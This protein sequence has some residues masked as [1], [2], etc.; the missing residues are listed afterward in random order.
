MSDDSQLKIVIDSEFN[1]RGA[2]AAEASLEKLEKNSKKS[3]E[4]V[5]EGGKALDNLVNSTR[6]LESTAKAIALAS[7]A[8]GGPLVLAAKSY[9]SS[10]GMAESTS[11]TWLGTMYSLEQQYLRVGRVAAKVA[12]P[13]VQKAADFA[14]RGAEYAEQHPGVVSTGIEI[15]GIG[16]A[17]AAIAKLAPVVL[18]AVN[19]LGPFG[20]ALITATGILVALANSKFGQSGIT[21]GAQT[22]TMAAGGWGG[23]LGALGGGLQGFAQG[24]VTGLLSEGG[25]S[26]IVNEA[27]TQARS[28][29]AQGYRT[30]RNE[31]TNTTGTALGV[32]NPQG[33]PTSPF[34]QQPTQSQTP[35]NQGGS[36]ITTEL[37]QQ[38]RQ[39]QI[40][41]RYAQEDYNRSI[42]VA[43]RDFYRQR[44]Y[45]EADYLRSR[46][47]QAR[48]FQI[49]MAYSEQMFYRD[50]AIAARDFQISQSRNEYDYQLSRKRAQEDH[51]FS[52]KQIMLSGDALQYYYSQRQFKIDQQRAE[53]DYQLQKQRNQEDFNRQ[54][55]DSEQQFQL[56]R[57][58]TIKE[59]EIRRADQE[60]D[61]QLQRER[62]LY[63]FEITLS[64]MAYN[65]QRERQRR[66]EGFKETILPEIMLE[67]NYR[68]LMQR[69]LTVQMI[70][71][72]NALMAIFNGQWNVILGQ[73]IGGGGS[74]LPGGRG[75]ANGGYTTPGPAV[76][77]EGEFVMTRGTTQAA[78]RAAK[79]TLTQ[80]KLV[81]MLTQ[82]NGFTYNDQREF[83]RG[84]S[85]D[86]KVQMRQE[87]QQMVKDAFRGRLSQ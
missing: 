20:V 9:V 14:E 64:D 43:N 80:E 39:F 1:D 4:E 82:G 17:A 67:A 35:I 73:Q 66:W 50:R 68:A 38:M 70:N 69:N 79:G 21:A 65:F 5:R 34:T 86:E 56:E 47:R 78:E 62:S 22:L 76:V 2:K 63:Q 40:A 51:N 32:I 15:A 19:A 46:S 74:G 75:Y 36:F 27:I 83:Y 8:I 81:Q 42:F 18:T 30:T 13:W 58:Q 84:V 77:H 60:Y 71:D 37:L 41:Q 54:Q 61:F 44:E 7:T 28:G 52:L 26:S 23:I 25:I 57:A 59:Y 33:Q 12:L 87:L 24:A 72:F 29:I 11:R 49:Q 10:V 6:G 55:Q 53:E 85:T 16:M 45:D 48:D 3:K 31:V